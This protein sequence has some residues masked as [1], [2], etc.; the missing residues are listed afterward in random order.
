MQVL[1]HGKFLPGMEGY[2]EIIIQPKDTQVSIQYDIIIDDTNYKDTDIN[3]I[4]VAKV[5]IDPFTEE[6]II[7]N[8]IQT[9]EHTYTGIILLE[10]ITSTYFDNIKILFKWDELLE[11][12]EQD[13]GFDQLVLEVKITVKVTQYLGEE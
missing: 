1:Q 5:E 12:E 10:N 11:E 13:G 2:F 8:L 9:D 6:E 7:T 4:S 3:L